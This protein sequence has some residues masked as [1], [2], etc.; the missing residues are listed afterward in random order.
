[1]SI[2]F[3][4]RQLMPLIGFCVIAPLAQAD[5]VPLSELQ[6]EAMRTAGVISDTAPV[7]CERLRQV[8]F[9][10]VDFAGRTR[11]GDIV[12]LD[13]VAPHVQAIFDALYA[14][15]FPL[16]KAQP[17]ELYRGDDQAAM[18]DNNTSAFNA[19]PITGG[20]RWSLHAYGVA[21]DLNPWQN[22]YL[23][24][25]DTGTARVQPAAA[26]QAGINRLDS[27][28][29]KPTRAGM[30]EDVVDLFAEQG[31]LGWGGYWDSPIDYQHFE[32]GSRSLVEQ[33]A[34]ATPEQASR[35]FDTYI[36]G[37]TACMARAKTGSHAARRASCVAQSTR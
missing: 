15:R 13:A 23:S 19:R 10:H 5:I 24:F 36:A 1:M 34:R 14:R 12:V 26:A 37:Y 22:P 21:I 18:A 7:G 3:A 35:L 11:I 30:A 17:M 25:D 27:R 6:C 2:A 28:P 8:T 16:A 9:R 33:M 29:N 4:W 31:F 20:T 32:P